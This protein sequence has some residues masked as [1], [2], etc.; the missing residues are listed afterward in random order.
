MWQELQKPGCPVTTIAPALKKDMST[1]NSNILAGHLICFNTCTP[2]ANI[3][4]TLF[5][6][7]VL[8]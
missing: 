3:V 7:P 5:T 2:D 1:I 8:Y 6:V 4:L